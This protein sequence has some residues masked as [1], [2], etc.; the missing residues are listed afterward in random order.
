MQFFNTLDINFIACNPTR[1]E[2]ACLSASQAQ[3]RYSATGSTGLMR[4]S[5][6]S[7]GLHRDEWYHKA[8]AGT[9]SYSRPGGIY[10]AVAPTP[11]MQQPPF[12]DSL[13]TPQPRSPAGVVSNYLSSLRELPFINMW[14]KAES[15]SSAGGTD[16][17]WSTEPEEE[18]DTLPPFLM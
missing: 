14:K 12:S 11:T 3:I 18:E 7:I 2:T 6:G 15:E 5:S 17:Y 8:V 16:R 13:H 1:V 9:P 4:S 10:P